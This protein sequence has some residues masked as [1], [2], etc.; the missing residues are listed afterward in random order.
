MKKVIWGLVIAILA[1]ILALIIVLIFNPFNSRTKL[2]GGI[3]NSYLSSKIEG[4]TPLD[5]DAVLSG[6]TNQNPLLSADQEAAL[7]EMGV[8]VSQLPTEITP[9]MQACFV[10][11]LGAERANELV[12][13]ATPSAMDLLKAG[14]CI[15]Q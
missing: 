2:I 14:S 13:G 15:G 12:A 4:Y 8:D 3:I 6:S 5:K 10:E 1:M 11:K 9:A 7:I